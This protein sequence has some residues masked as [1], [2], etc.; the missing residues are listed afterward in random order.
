MDVVF[1]SLWVTCLKH[2]VLMLQKAWY[3][4]FISLSVGSALAQSAS[5]PGLATANG[6][7][8]GSETPSSLPWNTYNYCNAPHVIASEYTRP[9]VSDA[10]LVYLNTVIRHHKVLPMISIFSS[11]YHCRIYRGP[12]IIYTLRKIHST[13]HG[14]A[15]T[16]SSLTTVAPEGPLSSTTRKFRHGTHS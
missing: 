15:P 10:K 3:R 16:L 5:N 7:Y 6:V 9:N 8:N 2:S 4:L 11:A 1:D 12:R 13:P 14:T